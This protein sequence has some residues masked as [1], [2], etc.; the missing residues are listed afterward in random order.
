MPFFRSRHLAIFYDTA[1]RLPFSS[2]SGL[3]SD[4]LRRAD[5]AIWTL[6]AGGVSSECVFAPPLA[7]YDEL[8]L[9]HTPEYLESLTRESNLAA[10]FALDEPIPADVTLRSIRLACGGTIAGAQRTLETREPSLNLLGGFHHAFPARGGGFSAVNDVAVAVRLIR[11]NG[12]SDRVAIV[13]LDAHPP[14]GIAECLREDPKVWI[15]SLSGSDWGPLAGVDETLVAGKNDDGYLETLKKLLAR[16]PAP[17]ICFIIAGGDVLLGDRLG[18][19]SLTLEGARQRDRLILDWLGKTPSVW[20]PGGGYH[21]DSWRILAG[22]GFVLAGRPRHK[23]PRGSDPLHEHF[24]SISSQLSPE[25]LGNE[26]EISSDDIERDLHISTAEPKL[27]GFYSRSGIEYALYRFDL[28][29]QIERA[30]YRDLRVELDAS[31]GGDRLRLFGK[32]ENTRHLL[33][34][35][36]LSKEHLVGVEVLFVNWLT[37]RHPLGTFT[38]ARPQLPGQDVPGLGLA[39]EITEMLGLM[40]KRLGLSGVAFRPSWYHMAYAARHRCQFVDPQLQR[41]FLELMKD[42]RHLPLADATRAFAENRVRRN[43]E[44]YQWRPEMMVY[45]LSSPSQPVTEVSAAEIHFEVTP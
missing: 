26:T 41:E 35:N 28:L 20:L 11:K 17:G 39:R 7:S 10:I 18:R 38:V 22:T 45:W 19:L 33:I 30:G 1:Y 5:F 21:S 8:A 9:V 24:T 14:D 12:F 15:G 13:D 2:A 3:D 44:V 43:G 32:A 4:V 6:L 23:I 27:L 37:L 36:V 40:A 16:S 42:L 29:S 34:E 25:A 31:E